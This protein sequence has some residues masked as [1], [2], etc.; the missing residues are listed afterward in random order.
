MM[1]LR[2]ATQPRSVRFELVGFLRSFQTLVHSRYAFP[3]C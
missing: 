1:R 2:I 3:S